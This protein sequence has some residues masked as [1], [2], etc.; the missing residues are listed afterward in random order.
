MAQ[1]GDG[2]PLVYCNNPNSKMEFQVADYRQLQ[3][4]V[5]ELI[6]TK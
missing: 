2:T 1:A 3:D 5:V 6:G 4:A